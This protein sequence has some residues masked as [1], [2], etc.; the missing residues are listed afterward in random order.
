[1]LAKGVFVALI[2]VFNADSSQMA[3]FEYAV[4]DAVL[5]IKAADTFQECSDV[6]SN[7]EKFVFLEDEAVAPA[8]VEALLIAEESI[9]FERN[10]YRFVSGDLLFAV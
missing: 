8:L 9:F 10:N 4:F 2:V 1:M 7:A 5:S 3:F 6:F